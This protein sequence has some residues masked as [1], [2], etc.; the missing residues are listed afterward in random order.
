MEVEAIH[1]KTSVTASPVFARDHDP[2]VDIK[3]ILMGKAKDVSESDSCG[4]VPSLTS[5]GVVANVPRRDGS[6]RPINK[7]NGRGLMEYSTVNGQT[8]INADIEYFVHIISA[9]AVLLGISFQIIGYAIHSTVANVPEGLLLIGRAPTF[10][11]N[12]MLAKNLDANDGDEMDTLTSNNLLSGTASPAPVFYRLCNISDH[13]SFCFKLDSVVSPTTLW[14]SNDYSFVDGDCSAWHRRR[15]ERYD[16]LVA[17]IKTWT[18]A[19]PEHVRATY[20]L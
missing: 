3:Y 14:W 15:H 7:A 10:K 19:S 1:K 13:S 16:Q 11:R 20:G 12:R 6:F 2:P 9:V 8:P 4:F 5:A 18:R 17:R